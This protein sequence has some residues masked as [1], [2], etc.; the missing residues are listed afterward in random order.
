M[1]MLCNPKQPFDTPCEFNKL[2][3]RKNRVHSA[4]NGF[5]LPFH[6]IWKSWIKT[7]RIEIVTRASN[8]WVQETYLWLVSVNIISEVSPS[9]CSTVTKLFLY[10]LKSRH[11]LHRKILNKPV[12]NGKFMKCVGGDFALI[13][14]WIFRN[15]LFSSLLPSL[16]QL[17]HDKLSSI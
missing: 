9:V 11:F 15:V 3:N 5:K 7:L 13:F 14:N 2:E 4:T 16:L 12:F 1:K 17:K 6:K 10:E 8:C